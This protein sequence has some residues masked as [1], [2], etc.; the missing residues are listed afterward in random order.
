MYQSDEEVNKGSS[1]LTAKMDTLKN[2]HKKITSDFEQAQQSVHE[3]KN[4]LAGL[5]GRIEELQKQI[6]TNTKQRDELQQ[7]IDTLLITESY[8]S[9]QEVQ[10]ALATKILVKGEEE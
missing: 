7:T 8:S 1:E 10:K 9:E 6:S 2:E 4:K 3:N 5:A